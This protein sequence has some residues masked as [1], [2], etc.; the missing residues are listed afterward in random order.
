MNKSLTFQGLD[1]A[2]QIFFSNFGIN[3]LPLQISHLHS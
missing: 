2:R 1:L 3:P